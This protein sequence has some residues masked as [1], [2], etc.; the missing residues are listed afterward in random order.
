MW[1]GGTL[2]LH[3]KIIMKWITVPPPKKKKK[4]EHR[5]KTWVN[6]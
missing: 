1:E 3:A 6:Q 4:K 2:N 5:K